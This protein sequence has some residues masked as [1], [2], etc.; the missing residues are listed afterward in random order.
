[1]IEIRSATKEDFD[2]I[3][4]IAF[5][6]WPS[7]FN[8]ILSRDQIKYM[9]EMMY[10]KESL[11]E[12]VSK[13]NHKFLIATLN[14]NPIDDSLSIGYA[15]Y[16]NNCNGKEKTKIHK[17]YILPQYQSFG[18]GRFLVDKICNLALESKNNIV[19]LNVNRYNP[20]VGFY[21]HIGF[22]IKAEVS[23]PIGNGFF[24]DDYIMEKKLS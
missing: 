10:S 23:I 17:L 8:S 3:R 16:Q 14:S 9:L 7:T 18:A 5:K 11:D 22:H 20:S 19:E 24:M 1:M 12:Q 2:Q 6:T 4:D 13:L 15:S 21:R